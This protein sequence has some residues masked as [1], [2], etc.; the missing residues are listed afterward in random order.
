MK[1]PNCGRPLHKNFCIHC[2]YMTNGSMINST[3]EQSAS[4]LEKYLGKDFDKITRNENYLTTF[5]LG[6][7]Y[8]S[9][10]YFIVSGT[11][12]S[13]IDLITILF[14]REI[15]TIITSYSPINMMLLITPMIIFFSRL[16][17]LAFDNIIYTKLLNI[18][19]KKIRKTIDFDSYIAKK[20][21]PTQSMFGVIIS[22]II[23]MI[24]L[25]SYNYIINLF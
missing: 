22:L 6:P 24:L 21:T 7:L 2:G 5:I 8:L 17:W 18:K 4:D 14:I 1:C 16:F 25:V 12:F 3:K 9:Y 10:S 23:I 11:I 13:I 15:F 20:K 19:I